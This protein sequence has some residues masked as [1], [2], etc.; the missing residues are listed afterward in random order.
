M[1]SVSRPAAMS[2]GALAAVAVSPGRWAESVQQKAP[3]S[4]KYYI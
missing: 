3:M 4:D 1:A 2:A